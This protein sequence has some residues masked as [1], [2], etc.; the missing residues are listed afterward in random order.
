MKS[1]NVAR[2][3]IFV[4]FLCFVF[5]SLGWSEVVWDIPQSIVDDPDLDLDKIK[6]ELQKDLQRLGVLLKYHHNVKHEWDRV[7][8]LLAKHGT[9]FTKEN[10]AIV[11]GKSAI[12]EL[13]S[14]NGGMDVSIDPDTNITIRFRYFEGNVDSEPVNLLAVIDFAIIFSAKE[15]Q[16]SFD[17]PGTMTLFHR[18]IC[19]WR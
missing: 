12:E 19:T 3:F 7:G 16:K 14:D 4:F 17:P 8:R 10:G 15:S 5:L 18:K 2:V 6:N 13:F 11:T 9:A 1:K